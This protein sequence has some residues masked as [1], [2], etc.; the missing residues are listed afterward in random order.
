MLWRYFDSIAIW[1][2]NNNSLYP[3]ACDLPIL[4][5]PVGIGVHKV[6]CWVGPSMSFLCCQSVEHLSAAWTLTNQQEVSL[7]V[8]S[9]FLHVSQ[10]RCVVS[11]A[12]DPN[13]ELCW[14]NKNNGRNWPKL[15][16]RT[17]W[18]LRPQL[19]GR[20]LVSGIVILCLIAYV[21]WEHCC[22]PKLGFLCLNSF[23]WKITFWN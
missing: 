7:L 22:L 10:P 18:P 17:Q 6:Q 9:C 1:Q 2:N 5:G 4:V 11:S 14:A 23:A 15:L 20:Y 19:V 8:W 12:M 3:R 16:W 21:F 13:L